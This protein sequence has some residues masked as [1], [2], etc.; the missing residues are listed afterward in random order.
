MTGVLAFLRLSR[1]HFL[2]FSTLPY[3]LGVL[4]AWR[5]GVIL[6]PRL[7]WVGL[8][9]QLLVQL[10][11]AYLNDY[12]DLLTDRINRR[13]TLLSGGSGE[14]ATGLL[15][16]RLGLIAG[17]V[18][19]GGALILGLILTSWEMGP[20]SGAALITALLAAVFYTAPPLKLSWRGWGEVAAGAVAALLVPQWA[21]SLQA[22]SFSVDLLRLS[23]PIWPLIAGMLLGIA[24]PDIPADTAVGKRTLAVRVGGGRI[25]TLY[26]VLIGV[27]DALALLLLPG[28]LGPVIVLA[29]LPLAVAG[30]AG[31]RRHAAYHGL[32]LLLMVVWTALVPAIGLVLLCVGLLAG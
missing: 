26:A 4:A 3:L 25:A 22:G 7:A 28:S 14:L 17:A 15:P 5:E 24:T 11:T 13:R 29:G 20:A 31:L 1:P 8:G 30:W 6:D 2:L 12:F 10:S 18:C 16:P 19:Q 32:R 23:L 27:G 9:A 21:Y